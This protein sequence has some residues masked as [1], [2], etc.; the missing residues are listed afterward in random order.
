MVRKRSKGK[1]QSEEIEGIFTA[2]AGGFGF[3]ERKGQPAIFIP[4]P[5]VGTAITG[6][7]VAVSILEPNGKQNLGPVGKIVRILSRGKQYV[8]G[9][10]LPGRWLRPLDEHFNG[11]V[12]ITGS[13]RGI[14]VGDWIRVRLLHSGS[15]F[16]EALKGEIVEHLGETGS[17]AGDLKAVA[18]EFNLPEPYSAADNQE[19]AR[20]TPLQIQRENL[21]HL[22]TVTIDPEDAKDFDDAVSI[23]DGT[24]PGTVQLGV[25]ISDVA[26][27]LPASR[28]KFDRKAA[29][30][31]FSAYLPGMFLPMLPGA[32]TSKISLRQNT[33]CPAHSILFTIRESTG[34]ILSCRRIHSLVKVDMRLNYDE[35]QNFIEHPRSYPADWTPEQRCHL[36][37]LIRLARRMHRNRERNEHPLPIGTSEIRVLCDSSSMTLTGLKRNVSREA[38]Q[39][40]EECMLAANSAVA[41]E[42]I[43]HHVPGIFRIHAEPLETKINDFS[44]ILHSDFRI[45]TGDLNE[46]KNCEAFLKNLPNDPRKPVILSNFLRALPRAEYEATPA[47]HYGLGKYRY[48]HFTSPIRRYPDL[49][50]HRQLWALDTNKKLMSKDFLQNEA[51]RCSELEERNE[52]AYFAAND[53]L[54]LHYLHLQNEP[55]RETPTLYEAVIA[56]IMS[57]GLLCNIEELGLFGFI[58]AGKLL[59]GETRFNYKSRRFR[60][61]RGHVQYKCGDIL[62][63]V[64]DSLDFVRGRAVF[65]P[66]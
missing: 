53:R 27:W 58:P 34:K 31:G 13:V 19:A 26:A 28:K 22:F 5:R 24:I 52:N 21:A 66:V 12:K 64:L 54:K 36:L 30:R 6:D 63:V 38:E 61:N 56:R 9:E 18:A 1:P 42:L 55:E 40:I 17:V 43:Q 49:L 44:R 50:I 20:L 37:Q 39:L 62:Y 35:M 3:V 47:L 32:L 57:A 46:R 60:A 65:R 7:R 23:A 48:L 59:R 2:A 41:Y 33:L 14:R 11:Q 8:V 4:L 25:H 16:T 29:E 51:R 15:K 10:L 45:P